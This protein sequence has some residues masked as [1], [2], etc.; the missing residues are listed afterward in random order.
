MP[1]RLTAETIDDEAALRTLVGEPQPVISA[2]IIGES[3]DAG[4]YDRARAER[5]RRGDGLY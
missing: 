4:E 3:F 5:Y 1:H 2:K